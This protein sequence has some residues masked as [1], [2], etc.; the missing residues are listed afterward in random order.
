MKALASRGARIDYESEKQ[1]GSRERLCRFWISGLQPR[2]SGLQPR[3]SGLQP[4]ISG[5]QPRISGLQL[6]ISD[7]L[8]SDVRVN[9]ASAPGAGG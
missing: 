4:R 6:R 5:L 3:I 7:M 1:D 2:I 8:P 9:P